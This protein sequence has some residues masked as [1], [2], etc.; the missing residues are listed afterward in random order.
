M[1]TTT[2]ST[3]NGIDTA[4]L[5]EVCEHVAA[6]KNLGHVHFSANTRWAGGTRTETKIESLLINNQPVERRHSLATDEPLELLGSDTAA[7]PQEMLLAGLAGCM[8]V[9]FV[10]GSSVHG[11]ELTSVEIK[12]KTSLDLRGFLALDENVIPGVAGIDY[13]IHVRGNGTAEQFE[14]IHQ[15]VLQ[16][17]PNFYNLSQ[18]IAVSGQ[19]VLQSEEN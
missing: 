11:I 10:A 19:V 4:A 6:D 14:A 1:T 15:H 9:G 18:P 13:E 3:I 5:G 12:T 7:N 16:T 8:M 2:Q 17:S